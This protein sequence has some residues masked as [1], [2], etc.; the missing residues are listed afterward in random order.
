MG[1]LYRNPYDEAEPYFDQDRCNEAAKIAASG[2]VIGQHIAG[3]VAEIDKRRGGLSVEKLGH[4][5]DVILE[6]VCESSFDGHEY[7][8]IHAKA[9]LDWRPSGYP[10][11]GKNA[12]RLLETAMD[13]FA[14][15][16]RE[17]ARIGD[18]ESAWG[19]A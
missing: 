13:A 14:E 9:S 17:E 3:I 7:S 8:I 1:A 15:A 4:I 5:F 19:K 11:P 6:S 10:N 18:L 12:H 16:D 2:D